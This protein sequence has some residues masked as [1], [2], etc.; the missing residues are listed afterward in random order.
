AALAPATMIAATGLALG[1]FGEALARAMN[2]LLWSG[3]DAAP[4]NPGPARASSGPA[5]KRSAAAMAAAQAPLLEVAQLSVRY[6]GANG[7]LTA[8]DRVS[9]DLQPGEIVG[10]VG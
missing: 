7:D 9:F 5:P 3:L 10:I 8:V 1:F 4:E 6:P 2:P